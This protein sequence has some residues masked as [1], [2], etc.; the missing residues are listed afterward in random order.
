M[1]SLASKPRFALLFH[2]CLNWRPRKPAQRNHTEGKHTEIGKRV[3]RE[4]ER[5][6]ESRE[7]THRE[8]S[9]EETRRQKQST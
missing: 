7:E 9:R 1:N 4:K 2:T 3:E 5:K 6:R 8:E